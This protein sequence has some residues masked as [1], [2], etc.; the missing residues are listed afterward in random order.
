MRLDGPSDQP[1]SSPTA[2]PAYHFSVRSA[3]PPRTPGPV[4]PMHRVPVTRRSVL[5]TLAAGAVGTVFLPRG[6]RAAPSDQLRLAFIGCGGWARQAVQS[7]VGQAYTAFCDVDEVRA[8]ATFAQ[9]PDVP[10]YRDARELLDRHADRI[11]AVIITTPDHSHYP[12]A[13]MCMEAG[14]PV[15]LEKPMATTAWECRRIAAAAR[16]HGVSTQLGLQGHSM[17][18]LR[19]L[20]EW[21]DAGAVGPVTDVWLWTDRTQREIAV[22]AQEPAPAEPIPATM[23]W[24]R[25]LADRPD[26]PYSAQYA[27]QRWRNWWGYGSGGICDIGMHMFDAV[28]F[29]LDTEF[30]DRV[31]PEVADVSA[32]TIPRWANLRF[33]FPAR[34]AHPALNVHWRNGWRGEVQNHPTAVPHV[35]AELVLGTTNGMAFAGPAGTLFIPDMRASRAPKLFPE[36]REREFLAARPAKTLP[37]VKGGHINNWYDAIRAGR[38]GD[39]DFTYGAALT[40]QVLLGALAERTQAPVSW[41]P[42]TMRARDNPAATAFAR[43]ERRA[44]AWQ[45]SADLAAVLAGLPA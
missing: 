40:E 6:L 28:R 18:G 10:R 37:R 11:D 38:P 14:K 12:L 29:A 5:K 41:D 33:E 1:L 17:E 39:S 23:D 27:P 25:W 44:D 30:P 24:R 19:V 3:F 36:S 15:Y 9:F 22:W 43:P 4:S 13:M 42:V 8:A 20:R 31:V 16:F 32:Y 7:E 34:G 35:P 26:R 45:P 2:P 21:L